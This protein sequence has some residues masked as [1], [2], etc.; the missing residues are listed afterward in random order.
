MNVLVV[1]DM[2]HDFV[3][4]SLGSPEAQAIV[5]TVRQK[6]ASFDGPV[7]FTRDTHDTNY[8]ESQEGQHLPVVHCV[9]D[10]IGWQIMESLITA[11]EKR[12]TIHPYF[13]IDKP[14]FGSCL[15]RCVRCVECHIVESWLARGSYSC[16]S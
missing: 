1:I 11:A 6:I 3:D 12:N 4:G 5:D 8:L 15:Y 9:K 14:N 13:I 7:I 2:Q 10:T 16:R